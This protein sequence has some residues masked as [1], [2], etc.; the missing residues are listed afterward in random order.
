MQFPL[1]CPPCSSIGQQCSQCVRG[2]VAPQ[3]QLL[4]ALLQFRYSNVP[5]WGLPSTAGPEV[6]PRVPWWLPGLAGAA[7]STHPEL[8]MRI[9]PQQCCGLHFLCQPGSVCCSRLPLPAEGSTRL[10][11]GFA[12]QE[13]SE[14]QAKEMEMLGEK[15]WMLCAG[16]LL[17]PHG[18]QCRGGE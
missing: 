2:S 13:F 6:M 8:P 16:A 9:C 7:W 14:H 17:C 12:E 18:F 1:L 5:L 3:L 15:H 11:P 10:V 4:N